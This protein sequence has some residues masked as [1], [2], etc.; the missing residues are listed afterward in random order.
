MGVLPVGRMGFAF[1]FSTPG[2]FDRI[3]CMMYLYT[4]TVV[5]SV[6]WKYK[7][8]NDKIYVV[9][10]AAAE[11]EV[12]SLNIAPR[13]AGAFNVTKIIADLTTGKYDKL[14]LNATEIDLS[15]ITMYS[16]ADATAPHISWLIWFHGR[17]AVND[18]IYLD[19][20]FITAAEP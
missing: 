4:G 6:I 18:V 11:I 10:S 5:Y 2:N 12:G 14:L 7:D 13:V 9:N 16:G 1:A 8:T 19:N 17:N 20:V 15:A 3:E